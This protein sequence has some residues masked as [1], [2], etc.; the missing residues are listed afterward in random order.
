MVVPWTFRRARTICSASLSRASR[1]AMAGI[2][3]ST[4]HQSSTAEVGQRLGST[5]MLSSSAA[6]TAP[7]RASAST[8]ASLRSDRSAVGM[9]RA[10]RDGAL[11]EL[12]KPGLGARL[13]VRGQRPARLVRDRQHVGGQHLAALIERREVLEEAVAVEETGQRVGDLAPAA[14]V[15]E[16]H[17]ARDLLL[18][19]GVRVPAHPLAHRAEPEAE[20]G[21]QRHG[22]AAATRQRIGGALHGL[23]QRP[24]PSRER[25]LVHAHRHRGHDLLGHRDLVGRAAALRA[26]RA[27]SA[28]SS[29][30]RARRRPS[31]PPAPGP[32]RG[33]P[34]GARASRRGPSPRP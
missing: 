9:L 7:W 18:E 17:R 12:G 11:H 33:S 22:D 15:A 19:A 4:L 8:A 31:P 30:P 6:S 1:L 34:R 20:R 29:P 5:A 14:L 32:G 21:R 24:V 27:P 26:P 10:A 25:G 13:H 2:R 23:A 28:S 3:R 16:R